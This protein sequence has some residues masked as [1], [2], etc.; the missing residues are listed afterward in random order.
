MKFSNEQIVAIEHPSQRLLIVAGAGAG[1]TSTFINRIHHFCEN[2]IDP[3][4]ILALTF[5]NAAAH[6]MAIRYDK[7]SESLQR[8]HPHFNTFHSFC[9][10]LMRNYPKICKACGYND[11]PSVADEAAANRISDTA[12][13][14][15]GAK[16]PKSKLQSREGLN[17]NQQFEQAA[18]TT[19]MLRLLKNENLITFDLLIDNIV[20]LFTS[21]SSCVAEPIKRFRHIFIDE[22]QDTDMRQWDMICAMEPET[23]TAIG[24]ANQAIYGFRGCTDKLIKQLANSDTWDV[25]KLSTNYRSSNQ[26]CRFA[27]HII[28]SS[29]SNVNMC[30]TFDGNEVN[31]AP[32]KLDKSLIYSE[33]IS[34]SGT[35][36]I[37][38]RTNREVETICSQLRDYNIPFTCNNANNHSYEII[39]G[40]QASSFADWALSHFDKSSYYDILKYIISTYDMTDDDIVQYILSN[41]NCPKIVQD[42]W[43][44]KLRI[45]T[46]ANINDLAATIFDS[47]H[48]DIPDI[49]FEDYDSILNWLRQLI[50]PADKS[51]YVGTIHSS[52][53]LEYDNVILYGVN[54]KSFKL[55]D[56]ESYNL[57]YVGCTRAR[58]HLTILKGDEIYE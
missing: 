31:V 13:M 17:A 21:H 7:L 27:N 22:F 24:D 56:S 1:K 43:A 51:I 46:L 41:S 8:R 47:V 38:A 4:S 12:Y 48:M 15:C 25:V 26:I 5:T 58:K 28:S 29:S 34:A 50:R 49:I 30:G 19:M 42:V 55:K 39:E 11:V 16:T 45:S 53:G 40:L 35:T 3:D 6:E 36:A 54:S 9:Y 18:Y 57:Y 10:T 32:C 33:L 44:L 23:I 2:D 52:K 20:N 14:M 37:L